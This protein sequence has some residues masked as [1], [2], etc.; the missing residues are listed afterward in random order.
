MY[1]ATGSFA[2]W[3]GMNWIA[4]AAEERDK[5]TRQLNSSFNQLE[6]KSQQLLTL[7][8]LGRKIAAA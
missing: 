6:E 7:H 3:I 4:D 2:A 1:S 8:T 5:S